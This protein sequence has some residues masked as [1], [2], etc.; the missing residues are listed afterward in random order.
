MNWKVFYNSSCA[1]QNYEKLLVRACENTSEKLSFTPCEG[2]EELEKGSLYL[3]REGEISFIAA[4]GEKPFS[5][6]WSKNLNFWSR[7]SFSFKKTPLLRAL[8]VGPSD[9]VV[10]ATCGTA[11]DCSYLLSAGLKV[12]AYERYFPTFLL[13]KYS[14]LLEKP[15][16]LEDSLELYFGSYDQSADH[17]NCPIY[18]DPMFDDGSKRKAKSNKQMSLFHSLLKGQVD[19]GAI[20]AKRLLAKT[21]RLVVKRPPKGELLLEKPNAQW[22]TKAVRFDLYI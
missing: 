7:E 15:P 13:L 22:S 19:D 1:L 18:Y 21:S 11:Q 3:N 2:P 5:L 9:W 17:W 10:D 4:P 16:Q 6:S 12:R 8:G 14:L 20:V